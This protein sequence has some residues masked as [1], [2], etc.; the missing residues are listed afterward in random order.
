M[1]YFD[2]D[3]LLKKKLHKLK[4]KYNLFGIKAEFEAEGSSVNDIIFLRKITSECNT[5]LHVKI[6]GVE[7]LNDIY[8]CIEIGVDGIISPM[9]ETKFG[10]HKFIESIKKL[11]LKRVPALSINIETETGYK[12]LAE[13]IRSAKNNI[14]NIT[15]G[16]SDFSE[17]FFDKKISRNSDFVTKKLIVLAIEA[18]KKG[19]ETTVGGGVDNA[20]ILNYKRN[21][22]IKKLIKKIETRKVMLP[23]K[24]FLNKKGALEACLDFEKNYILSKKQR[25]DFRIKSELNRLSILNNRE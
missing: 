3:I 19:I 14:S 6:G 8:N 7:A 1:N 15:L 9:V 17:S 5:K 10:L 25:S 18:K 13:I 20:T 2:F 4:K 12:N 16:R 22:Q 24:S 21:L 23:T 11:K